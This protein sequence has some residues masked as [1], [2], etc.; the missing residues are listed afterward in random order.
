MEKIGVFPGNW[1]L[2]VD[3]ENEIE[4]LLLDPIDF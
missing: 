1:V 4:R 2:A 3:R